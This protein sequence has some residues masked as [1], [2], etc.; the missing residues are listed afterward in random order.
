MPL[1][2]GDI[3]VGTYKGTGDWFAEKRKIATES[4]TN[5]IIITVEKDGSVS[6]TFSAHMIEITA[7][8][9][10]KI[11][12][13]IGSILGAALSAASS[14]ALP[15]SLRIQKPGQLMSIQIAL[16]RGTNSITFRS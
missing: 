14:L 10:V 9:N 6:G 4:M 12:P 11:A 7:D 2:S 16:T 15:V 5:E 13:H 3:P 8:N 1:A